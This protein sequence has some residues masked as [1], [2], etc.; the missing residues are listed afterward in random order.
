MRISATQL[1]AFR[2]F[3]E[4]EQEWMTEDALHA[5]IRGDFVSNH[6]IALGQAFGRVLESPE[7]YAVDGGYRIT[8]NDEAFEFGADV[9]A[10]ALNLIDHVHGVFEAKAVKS[11]GRHDVASKADYLRGA[12]LHEFK[13]TLSTFDFDKYAQ[14]VQWRYMVDAFQ[15]VRVTYHIFCLN[16]GSNGVIELR[17]IESFSLYPYAELHDDCARLVS[18]F[19]EYVTVKGMAGVL[20]Q[21]QADAA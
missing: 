18:Q 21:R 6:K 15:P 12:E 16:E 9:M 5:T 2:L 13:T 10:P 20:N 19:A 11:Y 17:G 3:M 4:P 7:F 14:S 8:A 1:D